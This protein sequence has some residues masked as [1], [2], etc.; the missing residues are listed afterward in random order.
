MAK[1]ISVC[2]VAFF[3]LAAG[4]ASVAAQGFAGGLRGVVKDANGVVPGAEVTLTNEGTSAARTVTSNDQGVYAFEN[5]LPGTYTVK[6]ALT[7]FKTLER[8][9]VRVG[10]QQVL[11]LD[12]SL[13]VGQVQETITVTGQAALIERSN[14]S[15]GTMLD[16]AMLETLPTVGRNAFLFAVTV[17]NVIPSGDPLFVRQQDQTNSALLS[18]AGGP[19]R[20]NNYTIDG[21][22]ITDLR[23]R[24]VIIPNIEAVEEVK[25]QVSTFDAEMGRTGGGVF[26]TLGKSG[27]NNWHG[28]ALY[29][30]RPGAAL[31]KF[32]FADKAD[33]PKPDSYYRLWGGSFGGPIRH[34]RTFFWAST[35]GY[36]TLTGR[37]T[38]L[39]LPT[40]RERNGD[41]SASGVTI[42]DPATYNPA[43]GTRQPFANNQIP[44]GR[45]SQVAREALKSLPLPASG[46]SLASV[47]GLV[48]KANQFTLKL[49]QRWSDK[50]TS[51][52]MY[53]WYDSTEP[54]ARFYGAPLGE[55]PGD[56]GDGA[57]FRTVHLLALNNIWVPSNSSV[58]A[59]RYGFNTFVDD[60][61]P[62]EFDPSSLG[63]SQGYL[64]TLTQNNL[65]PKFPDFDVEGYGRDDDLLGDRTYVPITWWSQSAN[66]SYS[67][68][69][70]KHT[71]KAGGDYRRMGVDFLDAGDTAGDFQ[72]TPGFTRGPNPVSAQPGTGDAFASFL[73]GLPATGN[74]QVATKAEMFI[75]YYGAYVQDDYRFSDN[76]TMNFG[77]RY[78]H[79]T[80]MGE[81]N[82]NIVVGW[83]YD[84]PFP[85]QVGG[86]N[87]KGGL[88]YAGVDGNPTHQSDPKKH[89]FAPRVGFAYSVNP[90]TV[91]RGGYGLFWAPLQ[92]HFPGES[93]YGTRGFTAVTD[94]VASFDNGL[95]PCPGCGIANPFPNGLEQPIGNGQGRL[96]GVGGSVN[97]ID[98]NAKSPYVQQYSVDLQHELPRNIAVSVGYIG[99]RSNNLTWSG[100]NNAFLN[101]N[102]LPTQFQ[103]LGAA[104]NDAVPNPFLGTP[105]A[106]GALSGA[107]V[108]RGQLLRP[109]P[110]FTDVQLR[111]SAG[112]RAQYNSAVLKFERRISGGWGARINYTF[113]STKDNQVQETSFFGRTGGRQ[114]LDVYNL[115]AEYGLS[116]NDQPHRLNL[117]G[118]YELPFGSGKRWL[119][120]G[121]VA[122]VLLGGWGISAVATYASGYPIS[123]FQNNNNSN[124]FGSGQRPNLVPDV[125]PFLDNQYDPTCG[126]VRWLNPAAWT[127]AAPFTFGNAPR[128]DDRVRTPFKK[129]LDI[130]VQ[131]TQTFGGKSL[132]VRFEVINALNNANFLG[133]FVGFGLGSFGQVTEVSGFPRLLQLMVRF[134]F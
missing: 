14:A 46:N 25:V 131:K 43:T 57:L 134:G 124:L 117:T 10:T 59:F 96:T 125:D 71:W 52:G 18:M 9:G 118:T 77:L 2:L 35:E 89:K 13:E 114:Y 56:P 93:A 20:G 11:T 127:A 64:N 128:T 33:V 99:S 119:N 109:Y 103:S 68:F 38:V 45:I 126:C 121:G 17:P 101:I 27:S 106:R 130:A 102:Q 84:N 21:V 50:L 94:Y 91:V 97:V 104:L 105:L 47:A 83:D 28:S 22:S 26:N 66:V 58:F 24:A 133:P 7:G 116:V 79:E 81:K 122:D 8:G 12:L 42:Y 4:A 112:A 123:V 98:Q 92:G 23:N 6:V 87:L 62:A 40:E 85:V 34:N 88:L 120:S 67:K 30:G 5:V 49:D 73:L 19:R 3:L 39:T 44:P 110:Q 90:T 82:D 129:N 29:Q 16:K 132:M 111:R 15:V 75:N 80:G 100:T 63:F 48:D 115:D 113:S 70:G 37:N 86:L 72:F 31:G 78:E 32:Y 41:F 51:T 69:V 55:N 53:G 95:T 54:E 74:I 108:T 76:L 1:T 61:V 60:C 107:T 36:Q 65:R